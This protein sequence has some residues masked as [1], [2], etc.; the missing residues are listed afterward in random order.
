MITTIIVISLFTVQTTII[1]ARNLHA[2]A[3]QRVEVMAND[4][5]AQAVQ[6]S[7]NEQLHRLHSDWNIT[8]EKNV[9]TSYKQTY[10]V[11]LNYKYVIPLFNLAEYGQIDGY[12]R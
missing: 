2:S 5:D 9:A 11:R 8:I 12:A 7:F 6:D 10:K 4:S 1:E 3:V